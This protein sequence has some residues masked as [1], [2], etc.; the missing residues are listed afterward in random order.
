MGAIT[1]KSNCLKVYP[2]FKCRLYILHASFLSMKFT[3]GDS[4]LVLVKVAIP[5]ILNTQ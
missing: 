4:P 3:G 5:W 1:W 2:S